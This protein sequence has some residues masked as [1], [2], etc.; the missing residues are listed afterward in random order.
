MI[1]YIFL[2]YGAS[3]LC[4]Y[5]ANFC[6]TTLT[7][8]RAISDANSSRGFQDAIT[9]PWVTKF[10]IFAILTACAIIG[11]G[12]YLFGWLAGLGMILSYVIAFYV[13]AKILPKGNSEHFRKLI[14]R[15]MVIR[16]ANF[17]KS[18]DKIRVNAMS[19]LL[20]RLGFLIPENLNEK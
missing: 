10:G 5:H 3:L 18:G 11:C 8:G 19:E 13:N 1:V 2:L 15:S 17:V 20:E 14:L 12:F 16:H 9:P 4:A 6:Q 7:M